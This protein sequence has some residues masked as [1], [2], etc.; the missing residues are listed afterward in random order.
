MPASADTPAVLREPLRVH[1]AAVES[2]LRTGSEVHEVDWVRPTAPGKWSPAEIA[3]HVRLSF[4]ILLADLHGER[5]MRVLLPAWQRVP[6]RWLMVPRIIRTGEFPKGAR[7]PK[8][9]RPTPTSATQAEALARVKS[10]ADQ[11]ADVCARVTRPRSRRVTHAYFGGIT[12]PTA[13]RFIA[14]HTQHHERQLAHRV[15]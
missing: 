2:F 1:A 3:E 6:L 13:L 4:E 5:A 12:L 15:S 10:A 14:R 7:A 8:E 11:F 9:I